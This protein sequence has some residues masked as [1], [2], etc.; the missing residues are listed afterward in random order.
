[1]RRPTGTLQLTP[2]QSRIM[3]RLRQGDQ[4]VAHRGLNQAFWH[5]QDG[6][7]VIAASMGTI[8]ILV[9]LGLLR[10]EVY[11][12]HPFVHFYATDQ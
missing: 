1:M 9:G 3:R 2:S 8:S 12:N 11:D 4:L 10:A 7:Q 5:L 6:S